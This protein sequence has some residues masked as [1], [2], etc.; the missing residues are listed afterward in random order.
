MKKLY[1]YFLIFLVSLSCSSNKYSADTIREKIFSNNFTFLAKNFDSNTTFSTPAGTGRIA[2]TTLSRNSSEN[3]G[4]IVTEDKLSIN[5]PAND[6]ESKLNL[7]SVNKISEDFTV[8]K[9]ILNNG[10]IL[11]NLFVNDNDDINLIKMEIEENGK[12]DCS[13]EGP[14]L[15]PIFFVGYLAQ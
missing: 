4:I 5:L 3:V 7:T 1:I 13:V 2:S 12:I 9:K 15:K 6:N 8:V 14:N 11:V 10:S